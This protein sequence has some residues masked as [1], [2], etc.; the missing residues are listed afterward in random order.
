[1][2]RFFGAERTQVGH[3][4]RDSHECVGDAGW[5]A[6]SVV[7]WFALTKAGFVALRATSEAEK[8]RAMEER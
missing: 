7:R 1:M 4:R 2:D 8:R 3:R 6:F 5:E